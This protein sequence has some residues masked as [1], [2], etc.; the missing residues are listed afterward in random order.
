M[1]Q[2]NS[3]HCFFLSVAQE[4]PISWWDFHGFFN[5]I[6]HEAAKAPRWLAVWQ[7]FAS[8]SDIFT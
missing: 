8:E 3:F 5:D 1:R 4:D 7:L 2:L 6:G